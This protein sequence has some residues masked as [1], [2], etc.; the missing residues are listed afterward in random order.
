MLRAD[1]SILAEG[2]LDA[3]GAFVFAY[4][5]AEPLTVRI[6]APGGHRATCKI[7]A[8]EL[9]GAAS[10]ETAGG[11]SQQRGTGQPR[12]EG[13]FVELAAGVALLLAAAAFV[14]SWSNHLRLRRLEDSATE[15]KR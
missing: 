4:Q 10:A 13:R 6:D 8:A 3:K 15:G 7:A 9:E 2:P 11:T 5:K 14:M 1:G 12:A